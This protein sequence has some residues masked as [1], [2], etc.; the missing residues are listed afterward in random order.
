[1]LHR[2]LRRATWKP[3]LATPNHPEYPAAHGCLTSAVA[4]VLVF[5]LGTNQ[6]DVD[7]TSSMPG[8]LHPVRHFERAND[9]VQEIVDARVWAGIHDWESG[10]KGVVLGRKVAGCF[11]ARLSQCG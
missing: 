7:D 1:M 10:I 6:I 5:F 2:Y 8:L 3:L 9:L 4:E 11:I